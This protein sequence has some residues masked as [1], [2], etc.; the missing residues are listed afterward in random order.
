MG[1]L[2]HPNLGVEKLLPKPT[3]AI[4]RDR[5]QAT[6]HMVGP[7]GALGQPIPAGIYPCILC[8]LRVPLPGEMQAG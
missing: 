2:R 6:A 5:A 7:G 8:D 1:R 3:P 4:A